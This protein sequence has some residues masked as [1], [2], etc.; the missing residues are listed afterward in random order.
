MKSASSYVHWQITT[1]AVASE[2]SGAW[3]PGCLGKR[4][5][6]LGVGGQE[7]VG[8]LGGPPKNRTMKRVES[9]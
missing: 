1:V 6:G 5:W 2:V 9:R 3:Q 7:L 8:E 4:V